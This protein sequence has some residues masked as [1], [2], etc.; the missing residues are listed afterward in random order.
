M[1]FDKT[2]TLQEAKELLPKVKQMLLEAN[3]ELKQIETR[4]LAANEEFQDAEKALA[5]SDTKNEKG[6]MTKLRECRATFQDRT[7]KLSAV[8]HEFEDCLL[9]WVHKITDFGIILRDIPTGLIDFPAE[10]GDTQYLLC[11][12][13]DDT[14]LDYWHLPTDGF[15]GRRPLAV[16]DEYF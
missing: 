5:T 3:D 11:W 12:R 10:K 16:L 4:L 15:V 9:K 6:D 1:R 8:Q 7:Q 14:D 13:L 2:F